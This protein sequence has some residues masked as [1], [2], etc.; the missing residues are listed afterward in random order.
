MVGFTNMS[1]HYIS[2]GLSQR[3]PEEQYTGLH[4]YHSRVIY[5][6]IVFSP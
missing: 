3:G 5:Q 4:F 2:R 1:W 6:Y